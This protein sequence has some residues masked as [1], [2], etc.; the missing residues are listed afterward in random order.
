M[1]ESGEAKDYPQRL[2]HAVPSWVKTGSCFHIRLRVAPENSMSRALAQPEIAAGLLAAA[3]FYHE[4][5]RWH[6]R[7][8]LLMPDHIHALLIFPAESQMS[9]VIGEWKHYA[10]RQ[11]SID[12]QP[13]Y[14]D[15]RIRNAA[16]LAEKYTYVRRNPVVK[17]LC[18][19]AEDWPWVWQPDEPLVPG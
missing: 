15:H 1:A 9:R 8:F 18:Q 5:Q 2:H 10:T 16:G 6:C 12:W 19:R 13:N 11:W 3:R 17:G 7:L 14:F 4:R